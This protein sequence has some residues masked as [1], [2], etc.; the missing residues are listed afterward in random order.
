MSQLDLELDRLV[1]V[2]GNVSLF[3]HFLNVDVDDGQEEL[4]FDSNQ[5]AGIKV[6]EKLLV[7]T[8]RLLPSSWC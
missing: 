2:Y 5:D 7:D 1:E 4:L 6:E 8:Q 3:E